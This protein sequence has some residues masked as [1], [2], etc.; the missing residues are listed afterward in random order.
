MVRPCGEKDR[1]CSNEKMEDGKT[2]TEMERCYAERH[3]YIKE[4]VVQPEEVDQIT[5]RTKN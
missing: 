3:T 5:W 2:K 4:T 1:R